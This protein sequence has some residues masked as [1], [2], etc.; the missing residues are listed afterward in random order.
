MRWHQYQLIF[1]CFQIF[2]PSPEYSHRLIVESSVFHPVLRHQNIA[3][4]EELI[5]LPFGRMGFNLLQFS[6]LVMSL[7]GCL[8]YLIV[9]KD[10][11]PTV[12]GYGN[13]H[14]DAVKRDI[15]LTL[16]WAFIM[17]PLT[18]L[19]D[20][21]S[22][23]AVSTV[24]LAVSIVLIVVI[25]TQ[26]PIQSNMA[27]HGGV[28]NVL[29]EYAFKPNV[30]NSINIFN[31]AFAWS[32]A[33]LIFFHYMRRGTKKRW[34]QVTMIVN[35]LASLLYVAVGLPG[36]L[37]YLDHTQG[38]ILNNFPA[39]GLV[40]NI[41][42]TCF[43]L[44]HTLT[45]PI[46]ALIAREVI[47]NWQE[48]R[49]VAESQID[50][51][52][53]ASLGSKAVNV[54]GICETYFV[55]GEKLKICMMVNVMALVPALLL[56]DLGVVLAL[57]GA[58]GGNVCT[59]IAPGLIYLGVNGDKFL[60]MTNR[61]LG[62]DD[63]SEELNIKLYLPQEDEAEPEREISRT[64]QFRPFWWY[65]FGFPLWC[66]IASRGRKHMRAELQRLA[67]DDIIVDRLGVL[68]ININ[69]RQC[70]KCLQSNSASFESICGCSPFMTG[71]MDVAHPSAFR[72]FIAAFLIVFGVFNLVVGL[73]FLNTARSEESFR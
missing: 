57:V 41:A 43:A 6:I 47:E 40:T 48:N 22:L 7:G 16:L 24:S 44:I 53:N 19:K 14:G 49:Q 36:Y 63:Q 55:S 39:E 54:K 2:F 42:R 69:C 66:Y 9:V 3:T 62:Y 64:N 21:S 65:L 10:T 20:V 5:S 15:V 70:G 8:E 11:A 34:F 52:D 35:V 68:L 27:A 4:F 72:F 33:A 51:V 31:E 73:L 59:W 1:A 29:K 60:S 61:A 30:V 13:V 38:D 45:Y 37:G 67:Q 32:Y 12:L 18:M 46:E 71:E 58:V 50:I 23:A 56:N 28:Y 25:A 17:V 26:S